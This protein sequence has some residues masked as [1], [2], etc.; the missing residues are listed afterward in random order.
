MSIIKDA[1]HKKLLSLLY[2]VYFAILFVVE[3]SVH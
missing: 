1:K 3:I 2:M